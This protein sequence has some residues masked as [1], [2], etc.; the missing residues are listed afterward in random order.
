MKKFYFV[1]VLLLAFLS[2]LNPV[3][4]Y[5]VIEERVD[6][7]YDY[8][9][10]LEA[11]TSSNIE[12]EILKWK[13]RGVY[14]RVIVLHSSLTKEELARIFQMDQ[15]AK[16]L[17]KGVMIKFQDAGG[18]DDSYWLWVERLPKKQ[19]GKAEGKDYFY[20]TGKK[21]AIINLLNDFNR[22]NGWIESLMKSK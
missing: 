20:Y 4:G 3:L 7:I 18:G 5:G 17:G 16:I 15:E 11:K 8:V 10:V 9:G 1:I 14:V 21:K 2:Y 12:K 19:K 6:H 13:E 22:I